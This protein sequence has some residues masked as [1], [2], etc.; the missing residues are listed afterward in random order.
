VARRLVVGLALAAVAK[1]LLAPSPLALAV[2]ISP[3]PVISPPPPLPS[4]IVSLPLP[5]ILP[6]V[7]LPDPLASPSAAASPS[8]APGQGSSAVSDTRAMLTVRDHGLGIAGED[9]ENVFTRFG[10]LVTRENSHIAG[11]G[12]GLHLARESARRIGGDITVSSKP[13]TGS[14]FTLSVPLDGVTSSGQA[15]G[16]F[17]V[18]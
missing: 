2:A 9:L 12:L 1:S 15:R 16:P 3:L 13:G 10:R 6:G 17:R 5:G 7:I 4:P 11:A 18:G 8:S 14:A